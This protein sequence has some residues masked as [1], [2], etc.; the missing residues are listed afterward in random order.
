MKTKTKNICF[1]AGV[2]QSGQVQ[3]SADRGGGGRPQSGQGPRAHHQWGEGGAME[4]RGF[5]EVLE[6]M[7]FLEVREARM[8]RHTT[9]F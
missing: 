2:Q 1:S 8:A 4:V 6:V 5:R 9:Y 3:H 7:E